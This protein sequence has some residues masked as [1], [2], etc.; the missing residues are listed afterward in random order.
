MSWS[1][2]ERFT[3][4]RDLGRI[5]YLLERIDRRLAGAGMAEYTEGPVKIESD[6]PDVQYDPEEDHT[7]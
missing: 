7:G 1:Q 5:C 3:L 4:L 2:S 6:M